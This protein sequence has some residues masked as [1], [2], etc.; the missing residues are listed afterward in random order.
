[1]KHVQVQI[2]F[3]T[4]CKEFLS[5]LKN[6]NKPNKQNNTPLHVACSKGHFEIS[7]SP[8]K[9]FVKVTLL[10]R[11]FCQSVTEYNSIISI[12][13]VTQWKLRNFSAMI[14]FQKFRKTYWFTKEFCSK[15][16]W[17]KKFCLAVNFSFFH[18]V[19]N[20]VIRTLIS[21]NFFRKMARVHLC[22]LVETNF[23]LNSIKSTFKS[24]IIKWARSSA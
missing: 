14:L 11:K 18:T 2:K 19:L 3:L 13:S 24:A 16:I 5:N 6:I 17:R 4:L 8:K 22:I 9:Y 23:L 12:I 21:R 1:M 10:S 15:L 7:L 20:L